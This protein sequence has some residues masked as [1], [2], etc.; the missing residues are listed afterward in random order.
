MNPLVHVYRYVTEGTFDAYLWQTVENKQRFISQI[1]TSKSPIRSCDDVDETA[2][3]FAEIKALCA[4]DPRIKERM[5]LDVDVSRLKL[6]KADHQSKLYRL[7]D[8]LLKYFPE[9]IEKHKGFIK[10]LETDIKTLSDN[11]H[12]ENGFI[13]MKVRD[14]ELTEREDAGT[15]LLDI[16]K[17][18]KNSDSVSLGSYRGFNMFVSF[19]AFTMEYMLHLKGQMTHSVTLG[20]DLRGNIIRIDNALNQ[21]PQRLESVKNQLDNLLRQQTAA[22]EEVKKPFPYEK[23]LKSKNIRLAELDTLLN[24]DKRGSEQNEYYNDEECHSVLNELKQTPTPQKNDTK[25]NQYEEIR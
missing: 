22:E 8:Q 14:A 12:P 13:G 1:M 5:D 23:D 17:E 18:I 24:I 21:M 11:P 10:G 6:M 2:L 15:A 3:S 9:E 20:T 19:N 25:T 16:C 4:G 7:E